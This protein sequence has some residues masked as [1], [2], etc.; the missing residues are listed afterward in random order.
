[1]K[2]ALF[3]LPALALTACA[4]EP[5]TPHVST[6]IYAATPQQMR[7]ELVTTGARVQIN[8]FWNFYGVT[9]STETLVI[10]T[11]T[12]RMSNNRVDTLARIEPVND[13]VKLTLS[14]NGLRSD[15][16]ESTHAK[17]LGLLAEKFK[18]L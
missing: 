5:S 16:A 4:P 12:G 8:D 10:L 11:A 7:D 9:S 6:A 17:F 15:V 2:K 18:R 13:G 14:T 1:M 3:L